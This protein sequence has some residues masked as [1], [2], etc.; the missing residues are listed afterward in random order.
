MRWDRQYLEF[1]MEDQKARNI[2]ADFYMGLDK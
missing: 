2:I 1:A